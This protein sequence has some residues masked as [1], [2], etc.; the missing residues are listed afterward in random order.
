MVVDHGPSR[1]VARAEPT[2]DPEGFPG[3]EQLGV[4][5]LEILSRHGSAAGVLTGTAD[6][7]AS[8]EDDLP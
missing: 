5:E 7:R 2:G 8:F 3:R 6:M 1:V 4:L